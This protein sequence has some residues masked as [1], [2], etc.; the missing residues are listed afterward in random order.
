MGCGLRRLSRHDHAD[1][2][3]ASYLQASSPEEGHGR[4]ISCHRL[5]SLC[6]RQGRADCLSRLTSLL[7]EALDGGPIAQAVFH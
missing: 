1:F 4:L 5:G 2:S 6:G 7:L 3:H